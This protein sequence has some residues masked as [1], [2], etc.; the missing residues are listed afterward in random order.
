M[1]VIERIFVQYTNPRRGGSGFK[2]ICF[3]CVAAILNFITFV[4]CF[5][6]EHFLSEVV[7]YLLLRSGTV[8]CAPGQI[9][10]LLHGHISSLF[11][12]YL[13]TFFFF[14]KYDSLPVIL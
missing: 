14:I 4:F 6:T 12:Y 11:L 10:H 5:L 2:L 13:A 7:A 1:K 3:V 9:Q 8:F